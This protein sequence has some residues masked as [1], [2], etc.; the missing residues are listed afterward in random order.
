MQIG[1]IHGFVG[2]GGGTEKT[3]LSIIESL[4]EK[5]HV[6]NLY[7]ISKPPMQI[8]G[9]KVR[10]ILPFYFPFFGL[11]QR[12]MESKLVEKAKDDDLVIQA[13]GGMVLPNDP[14]QKIIIYCHHDFP[15]ETEK[16]ITKYKGI[17]AWYYKPYYAASQRFLSHIKNDTLHLIANSR[18]THESIK[19]KFGKNSAIIYPP[20]DLHKFTN[21]SIKTKSVITISR[22]SQEKNLE[23]A[24]DIINDIETTYTVIGNTT[25]KTNEIY[26]ETLLRKINNK[27][28]KAKITLLKNISRDNVINNLVGAKVYLHTA[29]ETFGISVIE[30][31]AAGCI[32]IVP[33]NSAHKETVP[34][35]ELRYDQNNVEEA[36]EKVKMALAGNYDSLLKPLQDSLSKYDKETFKKS[37]IEYIEKI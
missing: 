27:K 20:V 4:L 37:I 23:L 8:Q 14:K 36:R 2:G 18:F 28:S 33:D 5:N 17:W 11:Y 21:N 3:L 34:Y 19:K 25:T 29:P 26:Y 9:V 6:V 24:I 7:T 35:E 30:G 13:S 16:T 1:I 22:F 12:Y 15:N 31:I 32:P 10:S